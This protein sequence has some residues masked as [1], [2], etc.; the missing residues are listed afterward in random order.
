MQ[1]L[2][3]FDLGRTLI[4]LDDAITR[5]AEEFAEQHHLKPEDVAWLVSLDQGLHPHREVFFNEVREHFALAASVE[6]PWAGYRQRMPQLVQC[7]PGVLSEL[8]DLRAAGW[9][10][11]GSSPT[12]WRTTNSASS[13]EPAW[14]TWL[15]ATRCR[16]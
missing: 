9:R 12:A 5:W 11:W 14:L 3:L 13:G 7:Y 15:T 8:A 4:D 1:R 2:A 6:E 16:G 10:A